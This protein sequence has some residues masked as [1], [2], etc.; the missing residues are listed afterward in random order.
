MAITKIEG[1]FKTDK[2]RKIIFATVDNSPHYIQ[3]H[4]IQK[5]VKK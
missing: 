3:M 2:I 4:Y 1:M 5:K